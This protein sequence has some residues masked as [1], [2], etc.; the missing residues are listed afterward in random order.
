MTKSDVTVRDALHSPRRLAVEASGAVTG[1]EG[2]A[3]P[4]QLSFWGRVDRLYTTQVTND[5]QSAPFVTN[6]LMVAYVMN[7]RGKSSA[8]RNEKCFSTVMRMN[9]YSSST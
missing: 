1:D 2:S 6:L 7:E 9:I 4:L 3:L 8:S 5:S